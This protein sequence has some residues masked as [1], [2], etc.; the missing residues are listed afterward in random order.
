MVNPQRGVEAVED[1]IANRMCE[2]QADYYGIAPRK[3]GNVFAAPRPPVTI[4][5]FARSPVASRGSPECPTALN[6]NRRGS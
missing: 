5:T 6:T 4:H 2:I 1:R 3:A